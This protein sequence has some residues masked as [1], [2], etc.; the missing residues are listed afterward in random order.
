MYNTCSFCL[1]FFSVV[2]LYLSEFVMTSSSLDMAHTDPL[3]PCR[4]H[5]VGVLLKVM[6]I[7]VAW[8]SK[9]SVSRHEDPWPK[10][11]S[12]TAPSGL[13]AICQRGSFRRPNSVVKVKISFSR[14]G[15]SLVVKTIWNCVNS[16]LGGTTLS[17]CNRDLFFSSSSGQ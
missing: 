9:F 16:I 7:L 5:W 6:S 3:F 1:S 14:R 4:C 13:A 12:H 15:H 2:Y 17:H 10:L 11:H 8:I